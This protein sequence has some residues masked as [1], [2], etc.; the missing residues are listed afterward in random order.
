MKEKVALVG[1]ETAKNSERFFESMKELNHLV[2]TAKGEVVYTL[3]QKRVNYDP[4]TLIGKGKLEILKNMVEAYEADLV[5][6]NQELSPRQGQY[7]EDAL[8]VRVIDRVQLILDIFAMRAQS[9]E[10]KLQVELAQLSY[11]LPRIMGQGLALSRLG[12]GIGTRGPGE[13]KLETDRRHIRVRIHAIK[14]ELGQVAKHRERSRQR[15]NE[16]NQFN[17]GLIGYTNA[18]KSTIMNLLTASHTYEENELFATL[19]PLT[20]Q[21]KMPQGMVVTLT[22]TVGFIQ[23]LPTELIDAF[24]S[25]LEESRGMDLLLH[26]VD[27]ADPARLEQE[28]TVLSLLDRLDMSEMPLLTVYTKEDQLEGRNFIPTLHPF[29]LINAKSTKGKTVLTDSVRRRMMEIMEPYALEVPAEDGQ[30]LS[31]LRTETLLLKEQFEEEKN[32]YLVTGFAKENSR[33]IKEDKNELE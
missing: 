28:K 9:K 8:G 19:D 6:F 12:G 23:D 1:I 5:I 10:G 30:T 16:G 33:W 14:K 3:T 7:L 21:W 31:R 4:K 24:Q 11:Q 27:A 2:K 13:T 26:V 25:T 29:C 18:G 20:K 32:Q 15:R 17:I 22:D